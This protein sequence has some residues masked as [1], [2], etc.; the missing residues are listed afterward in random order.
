MCITRE[1]FQHFVVFGIC[2]GTQV[3]G[4]YQWYGKLSME[5]KQMNC[6]FIK[7]TEIQQSS[8]PIDCNLER[9]KRERYAADT[10]C[11]VIL[12]HTQEDICFFA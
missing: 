11:V 6:Q 3:T 12:H 5:A 8:V 2:P 10:R 4:N 1:S 9:N 7:Q